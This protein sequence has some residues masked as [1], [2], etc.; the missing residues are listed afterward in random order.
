[1]LL[2]GITINLSAQIENEDTDRA[3]PYIYYRNNIYA[4]AGYAVVTGNISINFETLLWKTDYSGMSSLW[5]KGSAGIIGIM[6]LGDLQA[7][8]VSLVGLT[9]HEVSHFEY[10]IG[11]AY[12]VDSNSQ[13]II[14]SASVGYRYQKHDGNL[15]YR[16]GV[17]FPEILYASIGLSF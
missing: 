11:G 4:A 2:F 12:I 16:F 13:S 15:I 5:A 14:P 8:N 7:Y 3:K 9:G 1:M 17:G 10:S 6:M